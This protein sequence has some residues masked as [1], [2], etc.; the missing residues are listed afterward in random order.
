MLDVTKTIAYNKS[1]RTKIPK[2]CITKSYCCGL[3]IWVNNTETVLLS[4]RE[5]MY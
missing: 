2:G 1:D 3:S 5:N 4:L